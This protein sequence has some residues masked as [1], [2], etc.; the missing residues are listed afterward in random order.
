LVGTAKT[1]GTVIRA[2]NINEPVAPSAPIEAV[3][4]VI[5]A[6]DTSTATVLEPV[7]KNDA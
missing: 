5:P 3:T 6:G 2:G 7:F 4:A 1:I